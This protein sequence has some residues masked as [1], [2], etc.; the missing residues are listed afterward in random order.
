MEK[1][2]E[3]PS[4]RLLVTGGCGFIGSNFIRLVMEEHPKDEILNLD[5]LTYAGNPENLREVAGS[6]RYFFQ[7]GDV[8]EAEDVARAFTWGPEAVV[9]FAA[10]THVDRSITSPEAF[11]KTD[12]LGTYRLLEQAR[13]L[14]IRLVRTR[15]MGA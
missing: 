7:Q 8:C 11:V 6:S 15:F 14:E 1:R 3:I 9:N 13:E 10:E 5:K 12:V 2:S 4:M